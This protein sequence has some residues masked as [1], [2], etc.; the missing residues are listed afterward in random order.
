[1]TTTTAKASAQPTRRP[2]GQVLC[3]DALSVL[4][5]LPA[6]AADAV[7]TDPPYKSG[8]RTATERRTQSA[9]DKY[10]SGDVGHDLAE[11]EGD[12]RD[13]RSYGYSLTLVLAECF[14][15]AGP[16]APLLVFT[17][18]RLLP[19]TSDALQAAGWTWRGIVAWHKPIA[20]PRR[21]GF[22]QSTEYLLWGTHGAVLAD[23]NPVCLPGLVSGSQPRGADRVHIT[24]KPVEVMRQL[25]QVCPPGGTVLDPFTGSGATG[26][27]AIAEGCGFICIEMSA[28]YHQIADRRVRGPR[29]R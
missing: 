21:G 20:R 5:T 29:V 24:Q 8:G 9:R 16:G 26:Q 27:A 17:D 10:V 12:N 4:A 13:Q 7:I 14:R 25:V 3:G 22:S 23:R 28:H 6:G 1:M 18:W 19:I 11:F 2:A 15:V